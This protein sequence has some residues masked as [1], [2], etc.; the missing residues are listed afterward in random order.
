MA[1]INKLPPPHLLKEGLHFY[2]EDGFM[3]FTKEYHLLRGSCCG[4][5]CK[6]CPYPEKGFKKK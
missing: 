4:N 5:G 6:H 3:V 1:K 2:F